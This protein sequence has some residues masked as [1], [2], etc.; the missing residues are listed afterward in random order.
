MTS[1]SKL[2][3]RYRIRV[4]PHRKFND[5]FAC[6]LEIPFEGIYWLV[7]AA[8]NVDCFPSRDAAEAA[9][10]RALVPILNRRVTLPSKEWK[11]PQ[12]AARKIA[13]H[14][15]PELEFGFFGALRDA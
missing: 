2:P 15:T 4:F 9:A 5:M 12:K 6:R 13:Q 14:G 10:A 1:G 11:K 3:E 7:D 8:N